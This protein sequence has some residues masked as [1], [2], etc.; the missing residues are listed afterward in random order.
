[1]KF[2]TLAAFTGFAS[3]IQAAPV[4]PV[5]EELQTVQNDIKHL[6]SDF[7]NLFNSLNLNLNEAAQKDLAQGQESDEL[8]A[9]LG[10]SLL[11]APHHNGDILSLLHSAVKRDV[12]DVDVTGVDASKRG[13]FVT[14]Q[15]HQIS[16]DV[17]V[18]A[19]E[20][21]VIYNH[22][23]PNPD[24]FDEVLKIL[25]IDAELAAEINITYTTVTVDCV[26][27]LTKL[28]HFGHDIVD[29]AEKV[30]TVTIA[31]TVIEIEKIFKAIEC[32]WVLGHAL[33]N[34]IHFAEIIA[35]L[36]I[37]VATAHSCG[38]WE[39]SSSFDVTLVFFKYIGLG[40]V[41]G[42]S[43]RGGFVTIQEHQISIDVIVQAIEYVLI[44]NHPL[45][46]PDNFDQV[47]KILGID[48]ELAAEI[49]ITYTTV[50][51][52]FVAIL[53]KLV[54]IGHEVVD[55]AEKVITVTI[56]GVVFKVELLIK[57]IEYIILE[58]HHLP[59]HDNFL[60]LIGI[61]GI[62]IDTAHACGIYEYSSS[63][64]VVATFTKYIGLGVF[65]GVSF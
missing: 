37:D 36:G 2:S 25:G 35:I 31:G 58:H 16:I 27:I 63:F 59:S 48:A 42:F 11:Q 56:A 45:P 47:C 14:I 8:I 33:P 64:S 19:I 22:P 26:A 5:T 6:N 4:V 18:Q 65:Q 17:I 23:L 21:V 49:N 61:L 3:L 34:A 62:D 29:I 54:L 44:Y 52:D 28:I 51:V 43:K 57:A 20:Y 30:I 1:M 38:I 9:E 55:I 53:A 13:G 24:H 50:T 46:N 40:F 10:R 32:I 41:H 12:E 15:E 60:G 39:W 7:N